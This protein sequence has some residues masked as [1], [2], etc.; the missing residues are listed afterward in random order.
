M[1]AERGLLLQLY[2][3]ELHHQSTV[4]ALGRLDDGETFAIHDDR[5]HARFFVRVADEPRVRDFAGPEI[6]LQPAT[7]TTMDGVQTIRVS[8]PKQYRLRDLATVLAGAEIRTYEA[9][10]NLAWLYQMHWGIR[11]TVCVE[12]DYTRGAHVDRVYRNPSLSASSSHPQL[13]TLVLDIET[14]RTATTVYAV[15]L[16]LRGPGGKSLEQVHLVG[17]P[18][19]GDSENVG[20]CADEPALLRA[21][22]TTIR[23]WDPDILSGWNVIDFD[24]PILQQRFRAHGI[25][26]TIGRSEETARVREGRS[27]GGSRVIVPGR[28]V[29]DALH[30]MR[31]TTRRFEDYRLDTVARHILGRGKTIEANDDEDMAVRIERAYRDDRAAFAEYCLEDSRLVRDLLEKEEII[32]LTLQRSMLTGL[33][34]DRAWGNIPAF[35]FLYI[36]ELHHRDLVAPTLG[37]D[38]NRSGA[39]G[40]LVMSPDPGLYRQVLVFDFKS[41]YPSIIR[42][43]NI[44]PLS[45]VRADGEDPI[46]APNGAVFDREPAILPR[47]L[48]VFFEHRAQAQAQG[49]RLASQTYKILMN[50]FYGVLATDACRFSRGAIAGA[51][52]EFGHYLLRWARALLEGAGCRILYGDTDS[53][54]VDAHLGNECDDETV[55]RRGTGLCEWVNEELRKHIRETW[56]LESHLE[57]EFEKQYRRLLLPPMRHGTGGRAKG[58]AGLLVDGEVE[59]VGMEAVRRDWTSMAHTLQRQLLALLFQDA[60][61]A[62]IES[63]VVRWIGALRRGAMDGDLV[64]RKNLRKSVEAYKRAVPPHVRAARLMKNPSGVISYVMTVRGPQPVNQVTAEL[65]YEHYIKTQIEPLLRTLAAVMPFDVDGAVKGVLDL[66]SPT[67]ASTQV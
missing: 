47:L 19:A 2:T 35:E 5:L 52:T 29:L 59:V 61:A 1:S 17:P 64:Y 44:D 48:A 24:M 26:F 3:R 49:N 25:P 56:H 28:Q 54:F 45:Y 58:Y 60:A 40:G 63:H 18:H 43:F 27:W 66:F 62:T 33:P 22:A 65:D 15:S 8:C 37:V 21:L 16:V 30:L 46:R 42:T 4:C 36:S 39:P 57:L 50:S 12:G 9:D 41:L 32:P 38:R 53:L 6:D 34:L 10:L 55:Y 7:A 67:A 51:I 11:T 20:C 23:E 14:D 31:A 13:T